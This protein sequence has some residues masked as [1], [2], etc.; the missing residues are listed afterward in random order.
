MVW[1]AHDTLLGR[2]VIV[3]LIH[4]ELADDPAFGRALTEASRRIAVLSIPVRPPARLG[5]EDGV[6]FLVREYVNGT[7]VRERV[8]R[9][10]PP[11]A[12]ARR[13]IREVLETLAEIH[14]LGIEH[15]ALDADDVII[16][17]DGVAR[18]TDL[19]IGYG[20]RDARPGDAA[21]LPRCGTPRPRA[22]ARRALRRARRRVR[23]G[24]V[25]F[26]WLTASGPRAGRRPDRF[27]RGFRASS[28]ERSPARSS[29]S[30]P[31]GTRTR[32]RSRTR[33]GR[34]RTRWTSSASRAEA[35]LRRVR[36]AGCSARDRRRVAA[37]IAIGAPARAQRR[38][39]ARASP[40]H[41]GADA[42][43][44]DRDRAPP[45]SP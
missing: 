40:T 8:G 45:P 25:L 27:G 23:R 37:A 43:R 32:D 4:P 38:R 7:G 28:T 41:R 31:I 17:R 3:R 34:H 12:E 21:G 11:V 42:R 2:T 29:P 6:T 39:P 20:D 15:L 9:T 19:G 14:D 18:L 1:R 35:A 44:P 13:G 30:R 22:G 33:S 16:G 10:V 24:A 5:E 36:M 26:E